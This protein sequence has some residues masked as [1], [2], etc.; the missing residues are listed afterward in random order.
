MQSTGND[1]LAQLTRE[2]VIR[3]A[4][5]M[6]WLH[7]AAIALPGLFATA[8]ATS[9][10]AFLGPVE[11]IH[12][13]QRGSSGPEASQC[14]TFD[15]SPRQVE[16]ALD[17]MVV[18]TARQLHDNFD[19]GSCF[20]RGR[21]TMGHQQVAWELVTGGTG[22]ITFVDAGDVFLIADPRQRSSLD[23]Q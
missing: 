4:A 15:L 14:D 22:R 6:K 5:R 7:A 1:V 3:L 17:R 16:S 8:C 23:E 18:I 13:E 9:G 10:G 12:V 21:A 19:I 11:D 2:P 20:V